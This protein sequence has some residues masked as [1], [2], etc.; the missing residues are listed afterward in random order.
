ME[1]LKAFKEFEEEHRDEIDE[2]EQRERYEYLEQERKAIYEKI[3]DYPNL[4]NVEYKSEVMEG[5]MLLVK[6]GNNLDLEYGREMDFWKNRR[7]ILDIMKRR[8]EEFNEL[9]CD[10]IEEIKLPNPNQSFN[11][12]WLKFNC[13]RL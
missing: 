13:T 8:F 1:I 2:L 5:D 3:M 7:H 10:K 9:R 6:I 11:D 4:K 12:I